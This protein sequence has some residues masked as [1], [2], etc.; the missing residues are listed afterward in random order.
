MS[1]VIEWDSKTSQS[2]D[3]LTSIKSINVNRGISI[4]IGFSNIS[5]DFFCYSVVKGSSQIAQPT[6]ES[7]LADY[8]G[9]Y[10]P[11]SSAT[12]L[13]YN[14]S[15]VYIRWAAVKVVF[16]SGSADIVIYLNK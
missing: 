16:V 11:S 2:A 7:E 4:E 9:A 3:Y 8:D 5:T 14:I 12:K 6:L 13:V 1:H 15:D 10:E